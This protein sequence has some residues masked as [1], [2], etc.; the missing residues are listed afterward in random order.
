MMTG[1]DLIRLTII[2]GI[3]LIV[4]AI[5]GLSEGAEIVLDGH[6][7]PDH[8]GNLQI[9][10]T[11]TSIDASPE[12]KNGGLVANEPIIA[13]VEP[14][15]QNTGNSGGNEKKSA[16]PPTPTSQYFAYPYPEPRVT[17]TWDIP[18]RPTASP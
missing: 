13:T 8:Y 1:L 2:I 6:I 9:S 10:P 17:V 15:N 11:K 18:P 16:P 7:L 5:V 14:Q 3:V 4:L 12:L